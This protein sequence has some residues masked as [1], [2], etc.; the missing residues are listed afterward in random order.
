MDDLDLTEIFKRARSERSA[1]Y[2]TTGVAEPEEDAVGSPA[3]VVAAN[4]ITV[5]RGDTAEVVHSL[6]G[7][8]SANSDALDDVVCGGRDPVRGNSRGVILVVVYIH[9]GRVIGQFFDRLSAEIFDKLL[10][11][12]R[13]GGS[14]VFQAGIEAGSGQRMGGH[15]AAVP[16]ESTSKGESS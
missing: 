15:V 11:E 3:H 13:D 6:C 4:T 2:D 16:L 14:H 8:H 1:S 9:V 5:T 7:G 10:G 12:D